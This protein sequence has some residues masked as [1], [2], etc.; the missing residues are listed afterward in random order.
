MV[1]MLVELAVR[2]GSWRSWVRA[3]RAKQDYCGSDDGH[4]CSKNVPTIRTSTF[5][6][7]PPQEAGDDINAAIGGV[8]ASSAIGR[9][10]RQQPCKRSQS[11]TT[12]HQPDD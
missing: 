12:W 1:N 7:P 10:E 3:A 8:G 11:Q 5:H 2:V 6:D 9:T 4:G